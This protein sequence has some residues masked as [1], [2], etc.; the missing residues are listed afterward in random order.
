[1]EATEAVP[2]AEGAE[3]IIVKADEVD[4]AGADISTIPDA[5]TDRELTAQ[6]ESRRVQDAQVV[7]SP[8]VLANAV[9]DRQKPMPRP[10]LRREGSAPPPPQ[11]PP[12]SS[13]QQMEE[14]TGNATDSLS[15][16]QLRRLVTEL[17]RFE[18]TAYAFTYSDTQSFPE[19]LEEWF[20]YTEEERYLL[21]Q[22]K[23][24]FDHEWKAVTS[25]ESSLE[26]PIWTEAQESVRDVFVRK[27]LEDLD[28][29]DLL[30]RAKSV[31]SLAYIALGVWGDS[32]GLPSRE[33]K[34]DPGA[35]TGDQVPDKYE[36]S[37]FQIEW[38][39]KNAGLLQK[40]GAPAVLFSLLRRT[41]DSERSGTGRAALESEAK[42]IPLT[43]NETQSGFKAQPNGEATASQGYYN[44][45]QE[46]NNILTLLYVLVEVGR[47][48]VTDG[49]TPS[50]RRAIG[51]EAR[52]CHYTIA[53]KLLLS[54]F[55]A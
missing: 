42:L 14:E 13:P 30:R 41:Y 12:P 16:L 15:L 29:P 11:Q 47:W 39:R 1:M 40:A 31:E 3:P 5:A 50:I 44:R 35:D 19:E 38:I 25:P 37:A 6:I 10:I 21:T 49:Q 36:R 4:E 22:A 33:D 34:P 27:L 18:P 23:L 20:Q 46:T 28:Q 7:S 8:K 55:A 2:A 53:N 43:R 9:P 52:S 26:G 51:M 54:C 24:A 48:E 32:A 45:Q 17:P